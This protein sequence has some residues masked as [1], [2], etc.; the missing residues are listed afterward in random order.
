[1]TI[2]V[3]HHSTQQ[4]VKPVVDKGVDQLLAGAG[5]DSFRI[6]DQKK[7]WDGRVMTFS[8]TGQLGFISVPLAATVA[9]DDTNVTVE[10]ELP[11]M[12]KNFVGEERVRA[13]VE[14]NLRKM[15]RV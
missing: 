15:V 7:A 2:V 5:G 4:A 8:C 9:V 6:I 12:V 13:I 10:S 14:E 11:P 3:A 1:M